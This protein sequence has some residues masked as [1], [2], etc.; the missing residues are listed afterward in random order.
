VKEG[1]AVHRRAS[2][3]ST[4]GALIVLIIGTLLFGVLAYVRYSDNEMERR[5]SPNDPASQGQALVAFE[6]NV[7][8]L[9]RDVVGLQRRVTDLREEMNHIDLELA[10]NRLLY[11]NSNPANPWI[12]GSEGEKTAWVRTRETVNFNLELLK[13]QQNQIEN[14]G[15][16][17]MRPLEDL[18]REFQ[19]ELHEVMQQ[20]TDAD[21]K[22]EEDRDKLL[23]K[24]DD[25]EDAKDTAQERFA[26][27]KSELLTRKSQLES[28]IRELLEL[29]LTWLDEIKPDGK[30]LERELGGHYVILDIGSRDRVFN[31]LRLEVFQYV[32][33]RYVPKG[34]AEVIDTD[35]AMAT[36]R[37][38]AEEDGRRN[39]ITKGDMVG[40]PIFDTQESPVV[41]L[42]GEFKRYN[43]GDLSDFLSRTGAT[44]I[45]ELGPGVD[46]LIAGDRSEPDQDRAREYRV[47]AMTEDQL[48]RYLHAGFMPKQ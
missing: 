3:H 47:T 22:L 6:N 24:L 31:G 36:A 2:F 10:A 28:R 34:F 1:T 19:N 37:I 40:N 14:P 21:A 9:E 29:R 16:N 18:I 32:K 26:T 15:K 7:Q 13:S 23:T 12:M 8:E 41:V 39:P 42:A 20:I 48:I 45:K 43:K 35:V 17:L 46:Y 25:L 5:G 44:V 38:V 4:L 30:I 11:D 27:T 33:G